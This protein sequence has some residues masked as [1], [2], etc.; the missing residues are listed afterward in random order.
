M[1]IQKYKF[2]ELFN[3]EN[4]KFNDFLKIAKVKT[5]KGMITLKEYMKKNQRIV[6]QSLII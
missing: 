1:F 2:L 3:D 5:N 6:I 4:I